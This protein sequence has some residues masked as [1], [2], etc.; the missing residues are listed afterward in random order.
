M[1]AEMG[2]RDRNYP[3]NATAASKH[4]NPPWII[5]GPPSA[6]VNYTKSFY[7]EKGF[8]VRCWGSWNGQH[9]AKGAQH[10]VEFKRFPNST[11]VYGVTVPVF[12]LDNGKWCSG[13]YTNSTSD[14]L[15]IPDS[16]K[17]TA[18]FGNT[19]I[20]Y[21]D[22]TL[23]AWVKLDD[24][25]SDQPIMEQYDSGQ[26]YWS[27]WFDSSEGL[28]F[29]HEDSASSNSLEIK[30]NTVS[31]WEAGIWYHVALTR[32][33][34]N[35]W[36]LHKGKAGDQKGKMLALKTSDKTLPNPTSHVNIGRSSSEA[37]VSNLGYRGYIDDVRFSS[38]AF[39]TGEEYD[40]PADAFSVGLETVFLLRMKDLED[41]FING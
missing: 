2:I 21:T 11:V 20:P 30:Q 15:Q 9:H 28:S 23:E 3:Q 5:Y 10:T 8:V 39:Y 25:T 14:Y 24:I 4:Y 41:G 34:D 19:A 29:K 35:E 40:L 31:G 22:L 1:G 27:L 16:A 13:L 37:I 18:Q 32:N 7:L 26:K 17:F 12:K 36:A 33:S 6:G 38:K